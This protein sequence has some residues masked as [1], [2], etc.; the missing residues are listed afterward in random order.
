MTCS[1]TPSLSG[2]QF[3]LRQVTRR[4]KPVPFN[5]GQTGHFAGCPHTAGA[6]KEASLTT[7]RKCML[8][9]WTGLI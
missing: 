6:H 9:N 8:R 4:M 3:S 2:L 5:I 1:E 7:L